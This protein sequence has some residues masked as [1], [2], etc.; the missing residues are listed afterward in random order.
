MFMLVNYVI[1]LWFT[2]IFIYLTTS[3]AKT[4]YSAYDCGNPSNRLNYT[5]DSKFKTN[6][7]TTLSKLPTTNNGFGFYNLSTGQGIDRVYSVALCRGDI[8]P[9]TCL[10]CVK[11]AIVNVRKAC[12]NNIYVTAYYDHCSL[13]FNNDTLLGNNTIDRYN[14]RSG[15]QNMTNVALF[16]QALRSLLDKLKADASTGGSLRKFA[17]GN[18]PGPDFTTIYALMQ[19]TPDLSKQ[20]CNV[21]LDEIINMIPRYIPG[22]VRGRILVPMCNFQYDITW[23]FNESTPLVIPPPSSPQGMDV[24]F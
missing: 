8:N 16:N 18:T 9:D 13:T 1:L 3:L 10:S 23:F 17:S 5:A 7:D 24:H 4:D 21:C 20:E 6:L 11:D 14:Y 19:C 2:F 15:A 12:P 22:K